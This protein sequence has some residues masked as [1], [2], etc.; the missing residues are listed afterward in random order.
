MDSKKIEA[1]HLMVMVYN[2]LKANDLT[3]A[4][5]ILQKEIT[6]QT[7]QLFSVSTQASER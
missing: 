4:A 7:K 6:A 2:Q 3:E 1:L 5:D